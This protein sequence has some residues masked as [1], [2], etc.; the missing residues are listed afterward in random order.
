MKM[1]NTAHNLQQPHIE[2]ALEY[3]PQLRWLYY[4]L[5]ASA[6]LIFILCAL[7][8]YSSLG[9]GNMVLG[10]SWALFS[11]LIPFSHFMIARLW[12][13]PMAF[14]KV[15]VTGHGITLDQNGVIT[16]IAFHQ[17]SRVRLSFLPFVGGWFVL[18]MRD[19]RKFLFTTGL[20]RS[21]YLV[22]AL[23][24]AQPTLV[25]SQELAD[26]R[27]ASIVVD[28]AFARLQAAFADWKSLAL[29]EAG[30]P[31]VLSVGVVA[32]FSVR[33]MGDVL[34]VF[35]AIGLLNALVGGLIWIP[36]EL[37]EMALKNR[38]L[39][40]NPLN[41]LRDL[42]REQKARRLA[43]ALHV[44]VISALVYWICSN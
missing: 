26:Y 19:G 27:R 1:D 6:P 44:L 15:V 30:L 35:A 22:D 7:N 8:A 14:T 13:K 25:P 10:L 38:E 11:L 17:V 28:H 32:A 9:R 37:Y 16:E 24:M 42:K 20:E 33:H 41:P 2:R 36:K 3:R 31:L 21:D 23:A 34:V 5:L 40:V 18:Q 29:M 39:I 43:R 12:L 4:L